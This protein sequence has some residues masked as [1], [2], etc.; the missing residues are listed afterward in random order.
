MNTPRHS[1]SGLRHALAAAC[2]ACAGL[3]AQAQSLQ[4]SV[5]SEL[6][7]TPQLDGR[8]LSRLTPGTRAEQI[9]SQGGWIKVR[10]QNQEGWVRSMAVKSTGAP[11]TTVAGNPITGLGGAFSANSN[12]PT[13]TTGTRGLTKEQLAN[14]QPAPAEVQLLDRYAVTPAQAEQ[15]AKAGRLN[16]QPIEGYGEAGK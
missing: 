11:A 4:V 13:A 8:V 3:G 9:G 16:A 14:A 15:H 5:E 6:R 2:L 10:V 12:T 7:A 1:L